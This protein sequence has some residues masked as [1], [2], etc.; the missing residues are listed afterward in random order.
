[1]ERR[2]SL[3]GIGPGGRE[4]L[5]LGAWERIRKSGL[6]AGARRMLE[7]FPEVPARRACAVDPQEIARAL[8]S[9]GSAQACVLFS[10]DPGFY[11][12]AKRLLPLLEGLG[13]VEVLPGVGSLSYFCARLRR[14]W[15]GVRLVSAHGRDCRPA[16]EV[17]N[18]AQTFF[19]T[20]GRWTARAICAELAENGFGALRVFVGEQL[21]YPDERI[22]ETDAAAAA[23][24]DFSPLSVL[25]VENPAPFCPDPVSHGLGDGEFLRAQD[26][27]AVPMTKA[28]VRAVSVSRLRLRADDTVYD[29]GA[30]T[31]SVAIEAARLCRWGRVYAVERSPRALDVLR[32]NVAR[33]G[34]HNVSLV[35]GEA[36][37]ALGPL[38]PPAA[39]FVGGAGGQMEAILAALLEKNPSVRLVANVIA[40]ES[41]TA[42]LRAFERFGL[43][44][45]EIVQL[46]VARAKPVAGY[47]MM[48]GQN[49]VYVL[50]GEGPGHG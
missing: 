28:E 1:M 12:G 18:H 43:Q 47:R 23:G 15:E 49:P 4:F 48:L 17:W 34:L 44:N 42:A 39:A 32:G 35:P 33:F 25:L 22:T 36:P 46:G 27:P 26:G 20:G 40:L 16:A 29:V 31:G 8:A 9:D 19:L 24:R 10:G 45:V 37:G 38:P 6:L 30:G 13:E 11:S 21:S 41:L 2:I 7:Q 50:S 3:I 5:T 14:P